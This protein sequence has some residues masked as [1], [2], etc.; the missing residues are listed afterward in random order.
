MNQE[1][2]TD[3]DEQNIILKDPY[4][5]QKDVRNKS[6]YEFFKLNELATSNVTKI[7]ISFLCLHGEK[8]EV[9]RLAGAKLLMEKSSTSVYLGNIIFLYFFIY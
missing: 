2:T 4:T 5:F 1:L 6:G 8:D 9:T 7:S 3:V